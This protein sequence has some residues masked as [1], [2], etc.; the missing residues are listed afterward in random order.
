[1]APDPVM[2]RDGDFLLL[3]NFEGKTFRYPDPDGS[4]GR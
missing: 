4:L 3:R 2:G 1:L